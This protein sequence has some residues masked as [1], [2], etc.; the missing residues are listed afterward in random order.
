MKTKIRILRSICNTDKNNPSYE[1]SD[2]WLRMFLTWV[3][4]FSKSLFGLWVKCFIC[5]PPPQFMIMESVEVCFSYLLFATLKVKDVT[6]PPTSSSSL[7]WNRYS[8]PPNWSFYLHSASLF[9]HR[10]TDWG[11]ITIN[12][13]ETP[14]ARSVRGNFHEVPATV[15]DR[16]SINCCT[17]WPN[18]LWRTSDLCSAALTYPLLCCSA[19]LWTL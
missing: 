15:P 6:P 7:K 10:N 8:N 1:L 2:T 17:C 19:T 13:C 9:H 18:A 12:H 3:C 4:D 16:N 5:V 11:F 14:A